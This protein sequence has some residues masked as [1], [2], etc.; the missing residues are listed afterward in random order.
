M[1]SVIKTNFC[2]SVCLACPRRSTRGCFVF[3][4]ESPLK[5][6]GPEHETQSGSVFG[7]MPLYGP[8]MGSLCTG[9]VRGSCNSRVSSIQFYFIFGCKSGLSIQ[10][11]QLRYHI[12]KQS[13]SAA[14][15]LCSATISCRRNTETGNLLGC[16]PA[17]V[18]NTSARAFDRTGGR[19]TRL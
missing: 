10:I 7:F 12:R 18:P 14:S 17:S 9:R 3:S 8:I 5:D 15:R 6:P 1:V 16:P 13:H 4:L 11:S 19:A 2:L